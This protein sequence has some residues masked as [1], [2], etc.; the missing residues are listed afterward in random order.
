MIITVIGS[1]GAARTDLHEKFRTTIDV[2]RFRATLEAGSDAYAELIAMLRFVA[3]QVL[4]FK[5]TS[6]RR[7]FRSNVWLLFGRWQN[8]GPKSERRV[9]WVGLLGLSS[10]HILPTS[11]HACRL[12]S[13]NCTSTV[14]R[15]CHTLLT[16]HSPSIVFF[17][18]VIVIG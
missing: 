7:P 18:Q 11:R 4:S 12:C 13:V 16:L 10:C 1:R 9:C 5:Q 17:C 3:E 6:V 14:G 2:E 8:W 15:Y